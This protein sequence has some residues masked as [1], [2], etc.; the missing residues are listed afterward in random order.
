M[1]RWDGSGVLWMYQRRLAAA[2]RALIYLGWEQ[3]G[4]KLLLVLCQFSAPTSHISFCS[5]PAVFV[6]CLQV[7]S[8]QDC[9]NDMKLG[10]ATSITGDKALTHSQ[11][12]SG[13]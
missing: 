9:N 4:E 5:S 11:Q 10:K 13:S 8:Q 12:G 6:R 1:N 2:R 3:L 7:V